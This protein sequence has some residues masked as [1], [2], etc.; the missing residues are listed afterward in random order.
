[1]HVL[2]PVGALPMYFAPNYELGLNLLM[3]KGVRL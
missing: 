2:S 3:T 1:L